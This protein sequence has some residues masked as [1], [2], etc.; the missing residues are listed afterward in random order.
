MK[1]YDLN[2]VDGIHVAETIIQ[3]GEYRGKILNV[4]RGNCFGS[5]ILDFDFSCEDA[6]IKNDCKLCFHEDYGYWSAELHDREG[7]ILYVDGDPEDF[8]DMIVKKEI[9]GQYENIDEVNVYIDTWV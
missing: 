6:G 7:N 3:S 4:I 1:K 5:S 2:L 8:N 9:I